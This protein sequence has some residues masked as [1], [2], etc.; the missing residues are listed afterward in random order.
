VDPAVGARITV[1][2][3][4]RRG[5]TR[6]TGTSRRR[7]ET[8]VNLPAMSSNEWYSA[9]AILAAVVA[10]NT[11]PC[12]MHKARSPDHA[13]CRKR[14]HALVARA[15]K[16]WNK[17]NCCWHSRVARKFPA[18]PGRQAGKSAGINDGVRFSL[19]MLNLAAARGVSLKRKGTEES[20]RVRVRLESDLAGICILVFSQRKSRVRA[21]VR[22]ASHE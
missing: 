11:L 19:P 9:A 21:R 14:F 5:E 12:Q 1:T 10:A 22:E 7:E 2:R 18:T 4:G 13:A 20:A 15:L 16:T 3:R 6:E 8:V 17:E